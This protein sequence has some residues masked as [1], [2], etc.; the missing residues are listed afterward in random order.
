MRLRFSYISTT[1]NQCKLNDLR[2]NGPV[3]LETLALLSHSHIFSHAQSQPLSRF[4]VSLNLTYSGIQ[5][6][7]EMRTGS[8]LSCFL[9]PDGG[10]REGAIR[11]LP[12]KFTLHAP[13]PEEEDDARHD[14]GEDVLPS[15]VFEEDGA[16]F[17]R[18]IVQG[19]P[20][21]LSRRF[22]NLFA[23]RVPMDD[24]ESTRTQMGSPSVGV[25]VP[26][27]STPQ[28]AAGTP[29]TSGV[30]IDRTRTFSR[31]ST[32][33]TTGSA[34]GYGGGYRTRLASNVTLNGRRNSLGSSLW[35]R[36]GSRGGQH[37]QPG[38]GQS[39][40]ETPPLNF[41]QRLLLANENAV[42][43]IADLWV[44][45]AM[46]V[47]NEDP[48]EDS[49]EEDGVGGVLNLGGAMEEDAGEGQD[50]DDN[51]LDRLSRRRRDSRSTVAT[52]MTGRSPGRFGGRPSVSIHPGAAGRPR[53]PIRSP[54]PA[55]R[56]GV[57]APS[58][59]E[60]GRV[61]HRPSFAFS[62]VQHASSRRSSTSV[63]T[64]FSHSGVNPPLSSGLGDEQASL[65]ALGGPLAPI[66]ES[67]AAS[68]I[69]HASVFDDV[70]RGSRQ[71]RPAASEKPPS[72]WAQLP[73]LVIVQYGVMALHT[74]S[75][76]Q[77]FMS[78]LV[79]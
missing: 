72:L 11:L 51:E 31:T 49:D 22:S 5:L 12:E 6:L 4:L 79:S 59:T 7:M 69:G 61:S 2:T 47:D 67:R 36:R 50:V 35:R 70:E 20:K 9:G 1:S 66:S 48:F 42:T 19:I 52:R 14:D 62:G 64:I 21:K 37:Q 34:Y 26:L 30:R 13:I 74:T 58:G 28:N 3:Y 57:S 68:A 56:F 8:F 75:H 43:N 71:E 45:A 65:D 32:N 39:G 41:A 46:N 78:Y 29:Q 40:G 18:G 53:P 55:T 73:V 10:P 44:A 24:S 23:K 38:D 60:S 15:P 27:S 63:P 54:S 17:P 25:P 16:E 33:L 77:I 76:D